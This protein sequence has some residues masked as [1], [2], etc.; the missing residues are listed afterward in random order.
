[1]SS[2]LKISNLNKSFGSQPVLRN[3]SI[4]IVPKEFVS[5]LG[6]SGSGK[7]TLLRLIAG[8]DAPDMVR[9]QSRVRK[10]LLKES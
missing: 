2:T 1:V 3:L 4:E 5:V 9:F 6:S 10:W 8:F 7:T